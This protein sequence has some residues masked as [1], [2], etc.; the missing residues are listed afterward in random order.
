MQNPRS[1]IR[2]TKIRNQRQFKEKRR[3]R[4]PEHQTDIILCSF[5]E[6]PPFFFGG[7]V[8]FIFFFLD[9]HKI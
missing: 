9:K 5:S 2:D 7:Y 1:N 6:F 4:E 3:K 8:H